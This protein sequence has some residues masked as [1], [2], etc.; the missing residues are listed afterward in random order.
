MASTQSQRPAFPER[1][2]RQTK[3]RSGRTE[4]A[5]TPLNIRTGGVELDE[6]TRRHVQA[7]VSRQFAKF[8]TRIERATVRFSDVNGPKG[9]NDQAC[10]IKV[11]LAALPSLVVEERGVTP[12]EAYD[13][14][15]NTM[16]RTIRR[17]LGRANM[18]SGIRGHRKR[19]GASPQEPNPAPED[20]SL[21]GARVGKSKRDLARAADRPEKR[22]RDYPVDTAQVGASA[23]DR[24]AGGGSTARRNTKLNTAGLTA[25]LEDSA[26]DTPSRKSTRGAT[27]RAK[28]D[29][30]LQRRQTR[31]VTSPKERARRNL[32][33]AK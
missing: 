2:P 13:R 15:A 25:A 22:R 9:G 3:R 28:R 20:G 5:R 1:I 30:N 14:A 23:T 19:K 16:E 8:A 33:A 26:Q 10:T 27:N 24:K 17:A 31:K 21:I 7:R 32:A 29:S 4:A 11:V 6:P 12:R 18:G